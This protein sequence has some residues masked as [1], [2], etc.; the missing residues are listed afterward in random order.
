MKMLELNESWEDYSERLRGR[1][2]KLTEED[3]VY[4]D[5]YEEQTLQRIS[6]RLGRSREDVIAL[7]QNVK[8]RIPSNQ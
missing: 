5:G 6:Q 7:L 4:K 1:F 8:L 2:T 3:V